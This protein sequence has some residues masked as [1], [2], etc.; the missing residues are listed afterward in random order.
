[1]TQKPSPAFRSSRRDLLKKTSLALCASM[2][3]LAASWGQAYGSGSGG[4]TQHRRYNVS[5]KMGARMLD[6]YARAVRAMLALPPEDPRNWYRQ[7]LIHTLDCPHA[8]WW[9]LPWHRGYLGWFEQICREM[10]GDP[11]FALPY[12]DWTAEPRVPAGM[13]NDV[14]D[15]NNS[16]YLA[17]AQDFD[18][19]LRSALVNS[20]YWRIAGAAFDPHSR[21]GQLLV[22]RIRFAADLLFDAE[23]D[24]AGRMFFDQPGA[25]GLSRQRPGF[26]AAAANAVSLDTI[27]AALAAPDFPTFGSPKTSAHSTMGGYGILEASPHNNVHRC[28]GSRDCDYVTTQG[29][30]AD[31]MSPVDPIFFLHHANID[32]LWD[33]WTR[34]QQ[35]LGL[36]TL[37]AGQN[38]PT[39]TNT[40]YYRWAS[41]PM[42]FFVDSR[43]APVAQTRA[44]DYE[45]IAAF[46]YDYEPGSG[47]D[48]VSQGRPAGSRQVVA[49]RVTSRMVRAGQPA[50][51]S[52]QLS[53]GMAAQGATG[54][55]VANLT[56]NFPQMS[57]RAYAVLL[58]GPDDPS[59][60]D[61]SSPYYLGTISMFGHHGGSGALS[62]ALPLG[63]RLAGAGSGG[64][65]RLRVLP[66]G[67]MAGPGMEEAGAV[68]L[69]AVSVESY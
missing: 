21:Y 33:V 66:L 56:L 23:T 43:G 50:S 13:F 59:R 5:S 19:R 46:S 47:E 63:A 8:N 28:V 64:A 57:H 3:P 27:H 31:M 20:D 26:S 39:D 12:W 49:G 18:Y 6:S 44:G 69:L 61:P 22:R 53:A 62:Y 32:R 14:L 34:K 45:T 42:L 38:T 30:M 65:L 16:A 48:V 67:P 55:L 11:Q 58:N 25:R 52:V 54:T 41:E 35:R 10:S 68:E 36:P 9:F 24:P 29:F 7:A 17:R 40:D 4:G 15:P 1:M 2:L 51:A 60:I 37:P